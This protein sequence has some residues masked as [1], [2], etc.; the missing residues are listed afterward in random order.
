MFNVILICVIVIFTVFLIFYFRKNIANIKTGYDNLLKEYKDYKNQKE[1]LTK[2]L[3]EKLSYET[4]QRA[5]YRARVIELEDG[6]KEG[7]GISLRNE[8]TKLESKFDEIEMYYMSEGLSFLI[9]RDYNNRMAIKS[10]LTL[11]DKLEKYIK[12]LMSIRER[13]ESM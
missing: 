12:E 8:V 6:I 10:Y 4:Y 13:K 1:E 11:L 5:G 7:T 2:I 3:Q 9:K